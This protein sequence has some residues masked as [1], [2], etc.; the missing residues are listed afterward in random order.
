M[1]KQET[2]S[3]RTETVVSYPIVAALVAAEQE[4]GPNRIWQGTNDKSNRFLKDVFTPTRGEVR[5]IPEIQSVASRSYEEINSFLRS[6]GFGIQLDPF[7]SPDFGV[8]SVLELLLEW[9][10]KGEKT[11]LRNA[12][13]QSFPAVQMSSRVVTFRQIGLN[14][15]PAVL[16]P[17]K[18]GD[19]VYLVME[20]GLLDQFAGNLR[21]IGL[22]ILQSAGEQR[23]H[24][25]RF[26]GVMFPMVDL[27]VRAD[28]SWLLGTK[29]LGDDNF[30]AII[31]QAL[32]QTKFAMD[33][34][35]ALVKSAVAI[36]VTRSISDPPIHRINQ[37]FFVVVK[38]P[39]L[40][41][42]FFVGYITEEFWKQPPR[43]N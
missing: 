37:P 27:D 25:E 26:V 40:K 30:P 12:E 24:H 6:R 31:S 4:I 10:T 38:R 19:E 15:H 21:E 36:A 8:A 13:N 28:I 34:L 29:T 18:S 23:E 7:Q 42:P 41:E 3:K 32:Q 16:I 35:G 22:H 11:T 9:E 5:S 20:G 14:E 1:A 33:D 43:I 39:A 17:T 2:Q